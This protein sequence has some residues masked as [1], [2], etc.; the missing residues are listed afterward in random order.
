MTQK[1]ATFCNGIKQ[2]IAG[3]VII[4]KTIIRNIDN[5]MFL[6]Y[7]NIICKYIS[8]WVRLLMQ[9]AVLGLF[10][11]LE[12]D[13]HLISRLGRTERVGKAFP[14]IVNRQRGWMHKIVR[15]K[16]IVAEFVKHYFV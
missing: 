11:L 13:I 15:I 8:L 6:L 2:T 4:T 5:R 1:T 12:T 9:R 16:T 14:Y 7:E 10:E 3:F